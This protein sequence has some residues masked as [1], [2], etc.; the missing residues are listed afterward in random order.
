MPSSSIQLR[1]CRSGGCPGALGTGQDASSPAAC[2]ATCAAAAAAAVS[3]AEVASSLA[4]C[5]PAA[6]AAAAS[7]ASSASQAAR[8]SCYLRAVLGVAGCH[9]LGS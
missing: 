2:R 7:R 1:D 5:A 3:A 4:T 8:A 9:Q 6:G